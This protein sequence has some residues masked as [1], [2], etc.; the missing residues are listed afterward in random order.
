[1]AIGT[2]GTLWGKKPAVLVPQHK[3]ISVLNWK[4]NGMLINYI[5][6]WIDLLKMQQCLP[7]TDGKQKFKT[8]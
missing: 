7:K 4:E 3:T 6:K 8:R 5:K 2:A 1:M